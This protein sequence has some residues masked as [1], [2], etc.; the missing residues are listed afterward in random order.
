[1]EK[2]IEEVV[3]GPSADVAGIAVVASVA[4][5]WCSSPYSLVENLLE[6]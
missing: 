1:M 6:P 2:Y 4:G 3:V 5:C